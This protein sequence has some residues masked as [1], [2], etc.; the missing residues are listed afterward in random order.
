MVNIDID[1]VLSLIKDN[2]SKTIDKVDIK[3]D[4]TRQNIDKDY[5]VY[6]RASVVAITISTRY[7]IVNYENL[8]IVY[9][10]IRKTIDKVLCNDICI[11]YRITGSQVIVFFNTPIRSEINDMLNII[12]TLN[13]FIKLI[14]Y[15]VKKKF[16]ITL[17]SNIGIDYGEILRINIMQRSRKNDIISKETFH[18]K[19]I[20]N[21]INL[22]RL[23]ID[24]EDNYIVISDTIKGNLKDKYQSYFTKTE[25]GYIVSRLFNPFVFKQ[26]EDFKI[27][28][29]NIIN[30]KK[31]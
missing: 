29:N 1:D 25:N 17:T 3:Q 5:V 21:A 2:L 15:I 20:D 19:P 22:S 12:A 16:N 8:Q 23:D 6:N 28:E 30:F 13:S 14:S 18:G 11:D 31:L 24:Y 27:T 10:T 7:N 26:T 4:F 9:Y